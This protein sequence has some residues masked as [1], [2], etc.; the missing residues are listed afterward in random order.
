VASIIREFLI[1]QDPAQVWDAVRDFD[2]VAQRLAP[3]FVVR[4]E[5]EPGARQL[6][7]ANGVV[8]REVLLGIDETTRRIAYSV[9]GGR[10]A[11]HHASAQVFA[12]DHGGTRFV[13]ITDVLPD[14]LAPA[15]AAMM[16]QGVL[17]M[18]T[19]LGRVVRH[20]GT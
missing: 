16:D 17:A 15:I 13:W 7:F 10:A 4:C 12:S 9:V 3:G 6:T 1:E 5:P 11:H 8:A 14:E 18:Q 19:A 2:A 20:S